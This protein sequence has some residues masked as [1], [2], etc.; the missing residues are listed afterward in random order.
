MRRLAKFSAACAAA[1]VLAVPAAAMAGSGGVTGPSF[2]V[3][4]TLYRTVGTPTDFSNT[5]APDSSFETMYDFG[6]LQPNVAE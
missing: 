5:R 1:A 4:G 6:G 3:D 2:Y